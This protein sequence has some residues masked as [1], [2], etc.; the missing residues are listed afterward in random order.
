MSIV[1]WSACAD[2]GF[3]LAEAAGLG[4]D[5][6]FNTPYGNARYDATAITDP[7]RE[8]LAKLQQTAEQRKVTFF[9]PD[10]MGRFSPR[11]AGWGEWTL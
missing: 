9:R 7:N 1:F 2:E 11:R 5:L 6:A 10:A 3:A 4:S 8:M